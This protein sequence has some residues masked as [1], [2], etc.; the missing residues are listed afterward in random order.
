MK[1]ES[2]ASEKA[3]RPERGNYRELLCSL[4]KGAKT[5]VLKALYWRGR[6]A[7]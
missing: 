1:N 4:L 7:L 5:T 3:A 2:A 6:C